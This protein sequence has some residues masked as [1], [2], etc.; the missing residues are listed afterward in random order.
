MGKQ[1]FTEYPEHEE[2]KYYGLLAEQART[3]MDKLFKHE[4]LA[5]RDTHVKTHVCVKGSLEIFDFDEEKIKRELARRTPLTDE[6]IQGISLKQGLL[7][8]PKHYPV[9]LRFANGRTKVANDYV[10]DTRSMSVKV[11]G[12]EGERLKQSHELKSQDII[13]QNAEVFFIKSIRDYYDFFRSVVESEKA[14]KQWLFT[15]PS[16]FLALLKITGRTPKSLLTERY[17]SGSAYALGLKTDFDVSQPGLV[18]VEY[19]AVIKY[20][21]TPI[22]C[23]VPH[24]PIPFQLRPG[25]TQ[26]PFANIELPLKESDRAK[27]VGLDVS[28]PDNYYRDEL[29]QELAK[30][31]SEYS[32]DLGIQFQTSPKMSIDDVTITWSEQESPF[33][34]VGRLT[35]KH[36]VIKFAKQEDF[37]ENLRF[38]PWNGLAVHRPVGA[39]NRIRNIV[40]P[41]V[42]EYR[43]QKRKL[44][45]QEP[46][47][48]ETFN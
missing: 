35:V 36:Q 45:Y 31:D 38:S 19:P 30:P 5:K 48:E 3:Q 6:Q 24:Q 1:L 12:V 22:S 25:L 33:F 13:V 44:N 21:F 40:Y 41:I 37:A 47:G 42:A 43:H 28:Q 16:Q 29:I 26:L 18:P 17:W 39:L 4:V 32:W 10:P 46:T 23:Q 27:A 11:M 2:Q 7:A 9:W 34:T 15:H 20:A 14:A 8:K